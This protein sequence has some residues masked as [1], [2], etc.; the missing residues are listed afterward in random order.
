MSTSF[1][2]ALSGLNGDAA[3]ID[4][5]GNNLANLT[6]VG[7]KAS[8]VAFHDLVS[9]SFGSN[10][11]PGLGIG[12]TLLGQRLP[13]IQRDGVFAPVIGGLSIAQ[14]IGLR[15]SGRREDKSDRARQK[16]THPTAR[17]DS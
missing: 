5:V 15:R 14:G 2:T 12:I 4:V 6:T 16:P 8:D 17:I 1:S 10:S 13:Q 3:A 7:F 9:E 11:K